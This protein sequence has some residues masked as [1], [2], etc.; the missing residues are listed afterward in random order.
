MSFRRFFVCVPLAGMNPASVANAPGLRLPWNAHA[1]RDDLPL[2]VSRAIRAER[3]D[4]GRGRIALGRGGALENRGTAAQSPLA[5][6]ADISDVISF[7]TFSACGRCR[8]LGRSEA[9]TTVI[10]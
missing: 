3:G 2:E 7:R 6:C 1:E 9:L 4:D 10:L 5:A 8:R